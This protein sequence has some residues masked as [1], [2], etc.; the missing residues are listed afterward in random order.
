[1][2]EILAK[3]E[4]QSVT[5]REGKRIKCEDR[6]LTWRFG[7]SL[8]NCVKMELAIAIIHLNLNFEIDHLFIRAVQ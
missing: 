7:L 6:I 5:P 4:S 1:M 3:F 2:I 8:V